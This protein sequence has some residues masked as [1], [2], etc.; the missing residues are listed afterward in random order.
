MSKR[1]YTTSDVA[2]IC[3]VHRNTII[4]AIRKGLLNIYRTPGGHARIAEEDLVEF[5]A[6]RNLPLEIGGSRQD[7]VLVVDDDPLLTRV[8]QVGLERMGY[9]VKVARNGYDAGFLTLDWKPDVILLDI[10]LPDIRG[11]LVARRI[12][13]SEQTAE[14]PILAMSAVSDQKRISDMMAA[15]CN[16]FL[17]KPFEVAELRDRVVK[18]LGPIKDRVPTGVTAHAMQ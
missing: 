13:E 10:M 4:G 3:N 14:L 8:V 12:R 17:P 6:A 9:R 11:E 15:G 7:K 16:D 1:F 2:R 18:L 5:C